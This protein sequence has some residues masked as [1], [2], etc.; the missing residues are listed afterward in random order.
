M[1]K[2]NLLN[3][4][5]KKKS[6]ESKNENCQSSNDFN[7]INDINESYVMIQKVKFLHNIPAK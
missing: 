4:Y 6:E 2:K 5:K 1:G 7:V 3:K